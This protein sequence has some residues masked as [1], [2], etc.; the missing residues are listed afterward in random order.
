[1]AV[2]LALGATQSR[3]VRELLADAVVLAVGA[4]AL[5]IGVA[6]GG[7]R[8]LRML[9]PPTLPR[10]S[11]IRVDARVVAFC[12]LTS[13]AT[14]L[15]FGL[16]P[17]WRAS[18]SD[19]AGFFKEGG[20]GTGSARHHRLQDTLVVLQVAVALVLLTGA[21]LFVE[22]FQHFRRMDP[23]F[24]PEGVL[25]AQIAVPTERYP[26]AE[27]RADFVMSVVDGLAAQPGID[28]ASA[29]SLL[30]DDDPPITSFAIVGDPTPDPS[31]V[32]VTALGFVSPSY[33]QTL[34]LRI[35][36]GR[37]VLPTDD[38]R[39]VKV[40]V[41]DQVLARRFF[42]G[43]DPLGL[44]LILGR[45]DTMEVVGV[46]APVKQGG[47]VAPECPGAL[48]TACA[49]CVPLSTGRNRGQNVRRSRKQDA[50]AQA[51]CG[52]SR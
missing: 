21:G 8:A 36:E 13:I 40:V 47:L 25:T 12:A 52:D 51:S 3:I 6:V 26:T 29:S 10:L 32:P 17:A 15:V 46:V 7:V 43:R 33:F 41:V 24:R 34:G 37:G 30:P 4:G 44:H 20:R 9:A 16:L 38:R 22:S 5:G 49:G 31:Q 35:R 27:Q 19:V 39:A 28:G 14:V 1:M 50:G 42:R 2:R 48:H 23:G 45:R 18:R 11:E